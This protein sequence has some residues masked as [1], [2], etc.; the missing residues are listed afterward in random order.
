MCLYLMSLHLHKLYIID[1][2]KHY[3]FTLIKK[4]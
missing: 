2:Y 1:V 3:V 4:T